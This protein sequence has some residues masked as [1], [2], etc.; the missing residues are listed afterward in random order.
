MKYIAKFQ[1]YYE[2][3]L[4]VEDDDEPIKPK[5]LKKRAEIALSET[6]LEILGEQDWTYLGVEAVDKVENIGKDIQRKGVEAR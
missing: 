5:E 1:A 4:E 2:I 6:T 3:E